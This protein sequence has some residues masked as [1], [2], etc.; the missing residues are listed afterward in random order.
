M[1]KRWLALI[2]LTIA[3]EPILLDLSRTILKSP[4]VSTTE[5]AIAKKR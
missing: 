5:E 4:G 2:I 3:D 1:I